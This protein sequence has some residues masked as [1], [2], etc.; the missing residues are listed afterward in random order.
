MSITTSFLFYAS[1]FRLAVIAAGTIAIYLG[2][3]LFLR[4]ACADNT[5]GGGTEAQARGGGFELTLKNAAPGS[6][7]AFF[8]AIVIAV[9]L[10]QGSPELVVEELAPVIKRETIKEA[11][12]RVESRR[13]IALKGR[14]DERPE[15]RSLF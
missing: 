3:K 7:F 8:G 12:K 5:G 4:G 14:G 9:M 2:Y 13:R 10:V 1:L 11:A 15:S 6:V